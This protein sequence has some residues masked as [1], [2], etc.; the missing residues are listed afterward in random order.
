MVE[1]KGN[2]S[3]EDLRKEFNK[4]CAEIRGWT[5]GDGAH[6]HLYYDSS[7]E[8]VADIMNYNPYDSMR[9]L[10]PALD[11]LKDEYGLV[12]EGSDTEAARKLIWWWVTFGSECPKKPSHFHCDLDVINLYSTPA[13]I[14][15]FSSGGG[16][17]YDDFNALCEKIV[18]ADSKSRGYNIALSKTFNPY[19]V[20]DD[21][22]YVL[23]LVINK[24]PS[25]ITFSISGGDGDG[26][27][28]AITTMHEFIC[29][30]GLSEEEQFNE[31]CAGL[32]EAYDIVD[33]QPTEHEF[34][35]P[36]NN[37]NDL[38]P[39]VSI[40]IETVGVGFTI[41]APSVDYDIHNR[42]RAY[43]QEYGPEVLDLMA[44]A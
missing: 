20:A 3:E 8:Y 28:D 18:R 15:N 42:L 35:D 32:V 37:T 38:T 29:M 12:P 5:L 34:F 11:I 40:I 7:D 31:M 4:H 22:L 30:Y 9:A 25:N 17:S 27:T 36:Y 43:A 39:I 24:L 26:N 6:N 1:E 21:T 2:K 23:E 41:E 44:G 10:Q 13:P 16:L 33:C 14:T 19:D